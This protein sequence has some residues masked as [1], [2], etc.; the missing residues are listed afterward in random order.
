MPG[1]SVQIE[2]L[3]R[4]CSAQATLSGA[5]M[6]FEHAPSVHVH[7]CSMYSCACIHLPQ[8]PVIVVAQDAPVSKLVASGWQASAGLPVYPVMHMPMQLLPTAVLV[9]VMGK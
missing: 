6:L 4:V 8:L 5:R 3:G 9:H 1:S 2:Q 7:A